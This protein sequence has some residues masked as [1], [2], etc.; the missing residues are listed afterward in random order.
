MGI[1]LRSL[2]VSTCLTV[3]AI[4]GSLAPLSAFGWGAEGHRIT[5]LVA[6]QLL[7]PEAKKGIKALMG[8]SDL[9]TYSLYLDIN[10]LALNQKYPGSREW[11]YDDRPVCAPDTAKT[12]YCPNGNCA[13]V[14]IV[15]HYRTLID[16]HSSADEKRFAIYALVHL[17]GDIHQPLHASDHEDRGG[18]DVKVTFELP[19][20]KKTTN[21]HSAWDT[22]FV[23]AA[24][25][26]TNE[27]KIARSLV[28]S[29]SASD[30]A[31]FKK[32]TP[33]LWLK[34]SFQIA[35]TLAYGKLPAF[36]C[37]DSDFA[38]EKLVLDQAYTDE[39]LRLVPTLLLKSGARIAGLLNRAFSR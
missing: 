7:T 20:G 16:Q 1:H 26:E 6:E 39:A 36:A 37:S 11:H 29:A 34:E 3:A 24:F 38:S 31:R 22:D 19:T 8:G 17:V 27:R 21:L 33:A 32:G 5:G 12:D 9:G 15:R 10:K 35:S 18:N 28:D 4:L 13:S 30:I 23:K 14:Q 2:V 25:E